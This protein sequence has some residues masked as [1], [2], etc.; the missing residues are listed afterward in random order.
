M[1]S[2]MPA[3]TQRTQVHR[4]PERGDYGRDTIDQILEKPLLGNALL[5]KIRDMAGDGRS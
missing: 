4:H 2:R 5:Q 3:P 1:L